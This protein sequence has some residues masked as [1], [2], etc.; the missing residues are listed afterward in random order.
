MNINIDTFNNWAIRGKDIA[1]QKYINLAIQ[2][3]LDFERTPMHSDAPSHSLYEVAIWLPLVNCKGTMGMYYFPI[4][5]T[6][7][8]RSAYDHAQRRTLAH[9]CSC[10]GR[11][12]G[13]QWS[14]TE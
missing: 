13:S 14:D 6:A 4:N 2:R 12:A 9:C 1:M 5:K 3:P 10:P 11:A 7:Q 8:A